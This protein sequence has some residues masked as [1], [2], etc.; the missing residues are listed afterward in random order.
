VVLLPLAA[1]FCIFNAAVKRL[2]QDTLITAWMVMVLLVFTIAQTKLDYYILA[3][4]P[5]FAIAI[6]ATTILDSKE[7]MEF[8]G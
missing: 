1:V 2:K 8:H 6:A 3:A 5:A 7:N 4:Y